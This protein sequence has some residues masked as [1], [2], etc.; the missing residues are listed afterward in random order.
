MA[1][2]V[3]IGDALELLRA[4]PA[5]SVHAVVT[6]PPYGLGFAGASWD[7]DVPTVELWTEVLRVLRPGGH[8]ASFGHVR[9]THRTA[10]RLEAAGFEIRD[11][12]AWVYGTGFPKSRDIA[13]DLDRRRD[14]RAEVLEI[15]A[16]IRARRDARELTNA[17]IDRAFG[18]SGMAAHWRSQ[19]SQPRVPTL[20]QLPRLLEVLGLKA[21]DVP[22][23]VLRAFERVNRRKG[24]PGEAFLQ[25]AIVEGSQ[26][27]VHD[28]S[29]TSIAVAGAAQGRKAARRTIAK[30]MP[31]TEE[32]RTWEGWQTALK[33][34]MEPITLAR[35]PCA[36]STAEN[37]LAHGTGALN[38]RACQIPFASSADRASAYATNE[39]AARGA[40]PRTNAILNRDARDR[41]NYEAAARWPANLL[42][43]GSR[44][45]ADALGDDRRLFY[46][47]KP[48]R[49]ERHAGLEQGANIHPTVKPLALMRWLCEL[50]TPPGGIVLDPF[51][52]SGT[53]GCA[54]LAAGFHFLGFE[55][56]PRFAAIAAERMRHAAARREREP[57]LFSALEPLSQP[58]L[59][60][61]P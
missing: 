47:A 2:T 5:A 19:Q 52:G 28:T 49:E 15:T 54:A 3:N 25:R 14:D 21:A 35:R 10:T 60:F 16:W 12:L 30:T 56:D 45:V 9:T 46:C 50:V 43:D 36:G 37:V 33:P 4:L 34:A 53:T 22:L 41:E 17:A 11:T 57:E 6:D 51:A 20:E 48:S 23:E 8:V 61:A 1:W 18:F 59:P 38:I 26:R 13:A 42:H 55:Q 31:A 7:R 40:G 44:D 27:M 58:E 24:T 32:A 39:H 29:R